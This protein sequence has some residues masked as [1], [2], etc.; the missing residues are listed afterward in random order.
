MPGIDPKDLNVSI[1]GHELVLNGEKR[2]S[3][4]TKEKNYYRSE[5]R[6]GSFHRTVPLPEGVDAEHVDAQYCNGVLT[7]KLKKSPAFAPK[8]IEVKVK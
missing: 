3:S 5:S 8:R 4:E 6:Y 1:T 2:E 7:L